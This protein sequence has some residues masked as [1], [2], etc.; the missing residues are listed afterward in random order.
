MFKKKNTNRKEKK[1][2]KQILR[3]KLYST[4]VIDN[5]NVLYPRK[6]LCNQTMLT[7][8]TN[9]DNSKLETI[10]DKNDCDNNLGDEYNIQFMFTARN[11]WR[12]NKKEITFNNIN[13][14]H[15]I[16]E[17]REDLKIYLYSKVERKSKSKLIYQYH[18]D[19]YNDDDYKKAKIIL[20]IGKTG[21]GK[22]TAINAFFNIIK[23]IKREDKYRYILIKEQKKAKGQAESQTDGLHIYYIKD[24]DNRP[25]IIIDSQGFGDTRGKEYDEL[26]NG[27]ALQS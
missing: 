20:F 1:K 6:T 19:T 25:I 27:W 7:I 4:N 10:N 16:L 15:E 24:K 17:I 18:F 14:K 3:K 2:A 8:E 23:G 21:D 11:K 26:I 5:S 13:D 12:N 22:T 9:F